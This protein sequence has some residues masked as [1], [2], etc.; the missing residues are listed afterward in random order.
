MDTIKFAK[1]GS[2]ILTIKS[3]TSGKH[4]T[5][6][7]KKSKKDRDNPGALLFVS[8]MTGRNNLKDYTYMGVITSRDVFKITKNSKFPD[9][10]QRVIAFKYFWERLMNNN[11]PE[12]LTVQH[13]GRCGR[14]G[15]LLTNPASLESGFG[16]ECRG[17][18]G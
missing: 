2:A 10:D 1:A 11:I 7:V 16:P 6:R 13:E 17:L 8:A 12:N 3:E 4:Y 18:V 15:R 14:C 5:Y 9:T